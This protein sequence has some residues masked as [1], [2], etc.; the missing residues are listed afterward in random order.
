MNDFYIKALPSSATS[1]AAFPEATADELR[2]L[3]A[4]IEL[5]GSK[6]SLESVASRAGTSVP[7]AKASLRLWE[8]EGVLAFSE[9]PENII[10][11]FESA[12]TTIEAKKTAATIRSEGLRSLHEEIA[13]IIEKPALDREEV[14]RMT[15][16]TT[17]LG[18]S[19]EYLITLA[20]FLKAKRRNAGNDT[21]LRIGNIVNHAKALAEKGI[22]TL[23]VLER[24]I[25]LSE[26]DTKDEH[27][28]RTILGIWGRAISKTQKEY[29]KKW[30]NEY[31]YGSDIISEAYDIAALNTKNGSLQYMDKVLTS[32]HEAGLKTA[33]ECRSY[34]TARLKEKRDKRSAK[35]PSKTEP[36][37]PKYGNF[38]P[39]AAFM[40]AL[41]RSYS[42][43]K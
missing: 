31:C 1:A 8:S 38:D 14:N 9:S 27:E 13:R 15:A 42:E 19:P 37:T 30:M 21:K 32:W 3:I 11:E 22:D 25:E 7:R 20:S 40:A 4:A 5:C 41:D 2:V 26:Q 29:F 43:E 39:S 35:K 23:E 36:E 10:D 34:D 17:D 28:I 24:H 18:L 33:E 12:E 16:L 6:A